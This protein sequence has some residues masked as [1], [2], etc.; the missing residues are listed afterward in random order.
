MDLRGLREDLGPRAFF[1]LLGGSLALLWANV[2]G[3]AQIELAIAAL[4]FVLRISLEPHVDPMSASFPFAGAGWLYWGLSMLLMALARVVR[5]AAAVTAAEGTPVSAAGAL[6]RVWVARRPLLLLCGL[7]ELPGLFLIEMGRVGWWVMALSTL[8]M[9]IASFLL[10]LR[11]LCFPALFA[12]ALS[13][14]EALR[15]GRRLLD[16]AE[17]RL[18]I[19]GLVVLVCMWAA[20]RAVPVAVLTNH[21][22][23]FDGLGILGGAVVY[24]IGAAFLTLLYY[25]QRL[26]REGLG[27]SPAPAPTAP[28]P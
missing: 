25:D 2:W 7:Y 11:C 14:S 10:L 22:R 6:R 24:P 26:R 1:Q 8:L 13:A 21:E 3:F 27:S 17:E 16:D 20:V 19:P 23:L 12:E 9:G 5:V 15:R 18:L 4:G 28:M